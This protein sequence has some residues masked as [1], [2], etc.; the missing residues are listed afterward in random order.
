MSN[1]GFTYSDA[2]LPATKYGYDDFVSIKRH[3]LSTDGPIVQ[4]AN[5]FTVTGQEIIPVKNFANNA[6]QVGKYDTKLLGEG[7]DSSTWQYGNL[8]LQPSFSVPIMCDID[9]TPADYVFKLFDMTRKAVYGDSVEHVG[10]ISSISGTIITLNT[11]ERYLLK[12][13]KDSQ[14]NNSQTIW[15]RVV[16]G[17]TLDSKTDPIQ[18]TNISSN[19]AEVTLNSSI[20]VAGSYLLA[21]FMFYD[22]PTYPQVADVPPNAE[23]YEQSNEFYIASSRDGLYY[24][25]LISSIELNIDSEMP[26]LNVNCLS[27]RLDKKTRLNLSPES[28]LQNYPLY[29]A[30][31]AIQAALKITTNSGKSTFYALT[32][33][34]QSGTIQTANPLFDYKSG[35]HFGDDETDLVDPI[36]LMVKSGTISIDNGLEAIYSSHSPRWSTTDSEDYRNDL[37]RYDNSCAYGFSS[38]GRKIEGSF[39]IPVKSDEWFKKEVLPGLN[40]STEGSIE[41]DTGYMNITLSNLVFDLSEDSTEISG[42]YDKTYNFKFVSTGYDAMFSVNMSKTGGRL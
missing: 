36:A 32:P 1:A 23:N 27:K 15:V 12:F 16:D 4:Y 13:L 31:K 25:S 6:S 30:P 20:S 8:Q 2:Y 7:Y 3:D 10:L 19:N 34:V 35:Y 33:V 37:S 39:V 22:A 21:V 5:T 41:I 42:E 29:A 9:N 11:R 17:N 40:S 26:S 38:N 18:I 14:N 28:N 24:P